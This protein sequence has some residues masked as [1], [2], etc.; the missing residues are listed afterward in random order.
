MLLD[1]LLI[2]CRI[3]FLFFRGR[4]TQLLHRGFLDGLQVRF[5]I[6]ASQQ[7][8][9]VRAEEPSR[10][11]RVPNWGWTRPFEMVPLRKGELYESTVRCERVMPCLERSH[12]PW[13][14]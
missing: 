9:K 14:E 4:A 12:Q 1:L 13:K 8:L 5:S 6:L 11:L 2:A 7:G 3:S 10:T